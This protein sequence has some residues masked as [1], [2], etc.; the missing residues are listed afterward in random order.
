MS[1]RN[2]IV[3]DINELCQHVPDAVVAHVDAA[4][5]A[6]LESSVAYDEMLEA[7]RGVR[8]LVEYVPMTKR[9]IRESREE[10]RNA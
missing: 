8:H 7:L 4:V 5:H 2:A 6:I 3:R 1:K 9:A 10:M